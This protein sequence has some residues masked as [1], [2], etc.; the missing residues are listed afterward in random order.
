MPAPNAP[1]RCTPPAARRAST[2]AAHSSAGAPRAAQRRRR[3][4]FGPVGAAIAVKGAPHVDELAP[5]E[6]GD[7]EQAPGRGVEQL[8]AALETERND[9]AARLGRVHL[10]IV[11]HV[12]ESRRAA[13]SCA[14]STAAAPIP[15][16]RRKGAA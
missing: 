11:G 9:D 14:E 12:E 5:L 2:I 6:E 13:V 8:E 7:A 3:S 1:P 4:R 16:G 15:P 10:A